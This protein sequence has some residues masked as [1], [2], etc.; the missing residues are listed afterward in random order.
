MGMAT[1]AC[2]T[3]PIEEPPSA[4]AGSDAPAP[5][6]DTAPQPDA[7]VPPTDTGP[8]C[9]PVADGLC[10]PECSQDNDEDCCLQQAPEGWCFFDPERGACGCAVEGPFAPPT[11]R[12]R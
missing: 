2:G 10:P 3:T 4:D 9:L 7:I 11:T 8:A 5:P 1:Q 6:T 12:R